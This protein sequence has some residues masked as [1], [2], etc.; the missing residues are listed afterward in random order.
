MRRM[1]IGICAF[2]FSLTFSACGSLPV[3]NTPPFDSANRFA[4]LIRNDCNT[5]RESVGLAGCAFTEDQ[6]SGNMILPVLWTGNIAATSQYCRNLAFPTNNISANILQLIDMYTSTQKQNCSFELTRTITDGDFTADRTM[7]GRFFIKVI[8]RNIYYH[9]MKFAIG[10]DSFSGV[11]WYQKKTDRLSLTGSDATLTIYPSGTRGVFSASCDGETIFEYEY[12]T[13]PFT[14][15]LQS[16][17]SCDYELS[18]RSM[19]SNNV[20]VATLMHEVQ[21]HTIDLTA[22]TVAIK[23][24]KI[25]FTF[26]DKDASGKNPVV[27]GLWV[28]QTPCKKTNSCSITHSKTR[29]FVQGFTLSARA[30]YGYYSTETKKWEIL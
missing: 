21:L 7:K 11:G 18:A 26:Q 13:S 30:F 17:I 6:L 2:F 25:S 24:N 12:K 3:D 1:L 15:N 22:P 14:V 29:Y 20:D 19:D 27:Y 16:E 23:K 8:P 9:K 28:E 4:M 10:K 5:T